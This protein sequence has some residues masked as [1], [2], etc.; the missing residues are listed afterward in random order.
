MVWTDMYGMLNDK[1]PPI[2]L[3]SLLLLPFSYSYSFFAACFTCDLLLTLFLARWFFPPWWWRPYKIHTGV[4]SQKTASL[5]VTA[6]NT[7]N[8]TERQTNSVAFIPQ[9]NNTDWAT[10]TCWRNL[11]PT[12]ADR[13]VSRGQCGGSPTVVN[14]NFV[15]RSLYISFK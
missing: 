1:T 6:V 13:R 3:V 15:Y 10:A 8:L 4:T 14:L 11:V 12:F 9:E 2:P 5:T 7:S